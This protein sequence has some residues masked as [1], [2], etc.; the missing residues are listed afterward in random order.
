MNKNNPKVSVIIPVHNSEEY[1]YDCLESV[2]KQTYDN[3]ECIL[4]VNASKDKS[5]DICNEYSKNDSRFIVLNTDIP[6]VSHARNM[7]LDIISGEYLCFIDSDDKYDECF[8]EN[9]IKETINWYLEN[10]EWTNNI[11]NGKY[12]Q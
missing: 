12:R 6:G 11:N 1:L 2:K 8:I 5:I 9:G 3:F 4:V 7:A 10:E